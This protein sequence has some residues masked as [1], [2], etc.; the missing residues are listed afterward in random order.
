[1]I[2]PVDYEWNG[3]AFDEAEANG[4]TG[5]EVH[6]MLTDDHRPRWQRVGFWGGLR[7]AI[8]AGRTRGG[9]PLIVA[10]MLRG[11]RGRPALIV[12]AAEMDRK[13]HEEFQR[14][15]RGEDYGG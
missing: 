2:A 8:I 1:M 7:T 13:E 4:V 5:E 11:G 12:G 15:E 14:W 6:E 10:F 3:E 9:R